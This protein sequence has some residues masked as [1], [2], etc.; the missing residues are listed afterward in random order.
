[1]GIQFTNHTLLCMYVCVLTLSKKWWNLNYNLK[2]NE[3]VIE[4]IG[5]E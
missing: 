2:Y 1:M 4:D 3:P 5:Q